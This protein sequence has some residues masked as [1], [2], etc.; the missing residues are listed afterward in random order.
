MANA[1]LPGI[2]YGMI[3]ACEK[4]FTE[5]VEIEA[6]RI[7]NDG[8]A[9]VCIIDAD[10]NIYGKMFGTGK[11]KMR[12]TFEIAWIKASQVHITGISTGEFE[13]LVFTDAIDEKK[14][15]I[16][17]RDFIGWKG[18]IP[19]TLGDGTALSV[20]FSGFRGVTD[21]ELIERAAAIVNKT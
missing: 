16:T 21:I 17:R 13:K 4:L 3:E 14:Y 10:G 15:G 5:Y 6:D 7:K 11:I 9:S 19:I 12:E 8:N 20:G 1:N 18:G 2:V